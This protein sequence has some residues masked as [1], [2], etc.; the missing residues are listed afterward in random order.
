MQK[1]ALCMKLMV[2]EKED[3]NWEE[4]LNQGKISQEM[5]IYRT[6][7]CG[8]EKDMRKECDISRLRS[9]DLESAKGWRIEWLER[10]FDQSGIEKIRQLCIREDLNFKLIKIDSIM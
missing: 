3:E 1:L 4:G 2:S 6:M 10:H 8:E 7:S 5:R 9:H